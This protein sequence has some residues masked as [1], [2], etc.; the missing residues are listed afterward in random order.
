[1]CNCLV[2]IINSLRISIFNFIVGQYSAVPII[3]ILSLLSSIVEILIL[4]Q[5]YAEIAFAATIIL[6]DL[7]SAETILYIQKSI[8]TIKLS[9]L[10][11]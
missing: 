1:M 9:L 3:L 7:I 11:R 6:K 2:V 5:D 4:L 10:L 8:K